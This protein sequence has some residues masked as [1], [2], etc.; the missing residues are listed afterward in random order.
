MATAVA[1]QSVTF[2]HWLGIRPDKSSYPSSEIVHISGGERIMSSNGP[3]KAPMKEARFH[4]GA[5]ATEDPEIIAVLRGFCEKPGSGYT[6]NYEEYLGHVLKPE[7]QLKRQ[8]SL[9]RAAAEENAQVLQENSR[10][11][12]KLAELE[13]KDRKGQRSSE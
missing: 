5:F 6:E 4:N 10:L 9:G 7:E 3:V 8:A 11:K 12:A 1:Q 2:Y 13:A